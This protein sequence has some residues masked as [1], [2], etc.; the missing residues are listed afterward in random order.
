MAVDQDGSHAAY[1]NFCGALPSD[2]NAERLGRH[3]CLAAPGTVNAA[4]NAGRGHVLRELEGTSFA[5]PVVSG[6]IALL[7]EHFRGQ[8]GNSAIVKRVVDTADNTGRYAQLEIYGAGLLDLE[9]ALQPAGSMTTGTPS[10]SAAA[11]RSAAS[12]PPAVGNLG[13]RLASRGVEVASLDSLGAPFWSSP[14]AYIQPIDNPVSRI[15]DFS[16]PD[17][18]AGRRLHLRFSPETVA[19]PTDH[20]GV[21]VLVGAGRVGLERGPADGFRWGVVGDAASWQGSGASGA[22]GDRV[23]SVT[24]WAGHEARVELDDAWTLRASATLALGHAFHEPGAMLSIDAH[25]LSA[26]DVG[27]ERGVRGRGTWSRIALSQPLR[28]ESGDATFTYLSGLED[29]APA[30]D[31]ATLPLAPEGREIELALT[32]EAPIGRGRGAI[33]VAHAWD[34]SHEPGAASWRIGVAYRLRW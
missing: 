4:G 17:D 25:A 7:M 30:Y 12:V 32:H 33:E 6:A 21:R 15:P 1:T 16:E 11:V 8:L 20:R 27:L 24:A 10:A 31:S 9:A 34:A 13:R 2:W 28:A 19:V 14:A 5:A 23:R 26:W 18:A 29:G 22:F 3:F